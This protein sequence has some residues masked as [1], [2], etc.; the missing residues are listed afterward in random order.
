MLL[1]PAS[2][3]A[4][5]G[6]DFTGAGTTRITGGTLTLG[7]TATGVDAVTFLNLHLASGTLSGGGDLTLS[8]NGVLTWTAGGMNGAGTVNIPASGALNISGTTVD[9][10]NRTI[11]RWAS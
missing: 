7:A 11:I 2:Y 3:T 5:I 9:F 8:T 10:R 1:F 4:N 6:T